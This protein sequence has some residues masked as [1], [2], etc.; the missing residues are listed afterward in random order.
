MDEECVLLIV[1]SSLLPRL[2][3]SRLYPYLVTKISQMDSPVPQ[4]AAE[5]L[6][7]LG[8]RRPLEQDQLLGLAEQLH[9]PM[10]LNRLKS[11]EHLV[12]QAVKKANESHHTA[13]SPSELWAGRAKVFND[14]CSSL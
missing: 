12:W 2:T 5:Q 8:L 6:E 10:L 4:L 1:N 11:L 13:M 7:E 3:S 9:E 14:F